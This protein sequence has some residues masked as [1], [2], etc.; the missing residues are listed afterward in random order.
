MLPKTRF[1]VW[2]CSDSFNVT[3]THAKIKKKYNLPYPEYKRVL[4]ICILVKK[5]L[6]EF[7][8]V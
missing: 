7:D 1:S 4:D 6:S 8:I 3:K 2:M 5:S